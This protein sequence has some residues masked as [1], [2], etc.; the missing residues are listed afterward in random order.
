VPKTGK[1][2]RCFA[3]ELGDTISLYVILRDPHNNE[4]EVNVIKKPNKF[5]LVM[6]G[7]DLRMCMSCGLVLG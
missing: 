2:P 5:S 6:G 7:L 3:R 1:L 4:I